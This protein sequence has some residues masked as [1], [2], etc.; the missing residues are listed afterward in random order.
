[1]R[2]SH[3]HD[4]IVYVV[5]AEFGLIPS[6]RSIPAYDRRMTD[7]R[8]SELAPSIARELTT[9]MQTAKPTELFICAGNTYVHALKRW[10][11]GPIHVILAAPGQGRKLR[12]LKNWL[13]G[14]QARGKQ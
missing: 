2:V 3:D 14:E 9:A 13:Y 8:A 7:E 4:L 5:S 12:S 10:Q 11:P 1:L 6:C